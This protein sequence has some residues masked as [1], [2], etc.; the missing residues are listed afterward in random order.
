MQC[1]FFFSLFKPRIITC[2]CVYILLLLHILTHMCSYTHIPDRIK[3]SLEKFVSSVIEILDFSSTYYLR[4]S[5]YLKVYFCFDFSV[6]YIYII[7]THKS[8]G[9][10]LVLWTSN[11]HRELKDIVIK[12]CKWYKK[13]IIESEVN[14]KRSMD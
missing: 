1:V 9:K 14:I 4:D 3:C 12:F 5:V 6:T 13:K 7:F 11:N 2:V 8:H 10:I